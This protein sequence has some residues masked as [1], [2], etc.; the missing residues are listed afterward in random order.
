MS[1]NL[2]IRLGLRIAVGPFHPTGK[3]DVF[4]TLEP[5]PAGSARADITQINF[6]GNA[7]FTAV[8][9]LFKDRLTARINDLIV[10][11]LKDIPMFVPQVEEVT[12]LEISNE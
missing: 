3:V 6:P 9:K 2:R 8:G 5:T 12:I 10:D 7:I 1:A 4:L 11:A